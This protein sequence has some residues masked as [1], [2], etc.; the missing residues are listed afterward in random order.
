MSALDYNC[1]TLCPRECK[2]DRTTSVGF[3]GMSDR[4]IAAKA[5]V[6]RSEEPC[7][8]GTRGS[9]AIF[10]SGCVLRCRFCLNHVISHQRYGKEISRERLSNI[11]MELAAKGV[12]N[13]NLVSA[14]QYIPSVESAAVRI[15]DKLSIPIVW[16]T[17]GYESL[18]SVDR[19]SRFCDVFLQDVKFYSEDVS[20]KYALANDYFINAL[21]ATERM[22]SLKGAP[23]FDNDGIMTS[24]VLIR[25]LVLPSNRKDSI[26]LLQELAKSIGTSNVILSL[27]SQYTPPAFDTGFSELGRRLTDFEYKSVC[28]TA[29]ELGFNGYFQER[30]SAKSSYTPIF[31][32]EGI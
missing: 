3:C 30:E 12:H 16:N 5:M 28:Q 31:D 32:L 9:G 6:H 25:H 4:L 27:M 21:R 7:I 18:S 10:F 1:C 17:G 11:M 29:L 20:Q 24:G 26:K 15:K 22:L 23:V 13:I 19:E 2:A 8:S 14:T